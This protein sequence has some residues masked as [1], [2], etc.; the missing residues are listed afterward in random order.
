MLPEG[1]HK[2]ALYLILMQGGKGG[3]H[4]YTGQL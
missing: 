4:Q 1:R 2:E 3:E